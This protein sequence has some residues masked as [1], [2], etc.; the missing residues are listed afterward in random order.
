MKL[1]PLLLCNA[2][3]VSA[4]CMVA[5]DIQKEIDQLPL[6]S[7]ASLT[8]EQR[9]A[10]R[11]ALAERH[12]EDYFAQLAAMPLF[13]Y[14]ASQDWNVF[15]GRYRAMADRDAGDLLEA[16]MWVSVSDPRGV[17][18]AEAV[19]K[20]HPD[21]AAAHLLL[22][23]SGAQNGAASNTVEQH[24]R[25][26]RRLCPASAAP[27]A[28]LHAVQDPAFLKTSLDAAHG[29]LLA[30][31]DPEAIAAWRDVFDVMHINGDLRLRT[32]AALLRTRN[33]YGRGDWMGLMSTAYL[34]TRDDEARAALRADAAKAL[35]DSS[36]GVQAALEQW[37]AAHL[38]PADRSALDQYQKERAEFL[39]G[40]WQS[41]PN[42]AAALQ[43][44]AI[45]DLFTA[46]SDEKVERVIE[47]RRKMAAERPDLTMGTSQTSLSD[48]RVFVARKMRLEE[49][50]GL[51]EAALRASDE[52]QRSPVARPG[53][54][55]ASIG[56]IQMRLQARQILAE[57]YL[58]QNNTEK[59]KAAVLDMRA[60]LDALKNVSSSNPM[61]EQYYAAQDRAYRDLAKRAG[62][63]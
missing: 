34:Y 50:P 32:D 58:L 20:R 47:A 21:S 43:Q 15:L 8:L 16:Q 3:L 25:E 13:A 31:S 33:L 63:E 29:M 9:M 12:P 48:A 60:D 37:Q 24:F 22:L 55:A 38:A 44:L 59:A 11:R 53:P 39:Y 45:T 61:F 6:L 46:L 14:N 36:Y 28:Y 1:I 52:Q 62:V 54:P 57:C 27:F 7:D 4:G 41:H 40:F 35:P 56:P 18:L 30:R 26:Y 5:P 19:W 17:E 10:P 49:V 51:V 23:R 2:A 42:S